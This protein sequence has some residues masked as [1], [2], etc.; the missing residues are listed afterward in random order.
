M[1]GTV[2]EMD[3]N[4]QSDIFLSMVQ[5][6]ATELDL[7]Q[8]NNWLLCYLVLDI[9]LVPVLQLFKFNFQIVV[10]QNSGERWAVD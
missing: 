8:V 7:H 10:P 9:V 5:D 2:L 1:I 3:A 6:I 4:E